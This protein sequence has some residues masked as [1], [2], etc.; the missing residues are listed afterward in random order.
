MYII[1]L[2]YIIDVGTFLLLTVLSSSITSSVGDNPLLV[3]DLTYGSSTQSL[4][5]AMPTL[6]WTTDLSNVDMSAQTS[7]RLGDT[8]FESRLTIMNINS[9]YCG[10]FSCTGSDINTAQ[11]S[12]ASTRVDVGML[13]CIVRQQYN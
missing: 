11:P 1:F 2:P 5:A 9:S 3:C 7:S 4:D 8:R 12:T 6:T 10:E 13:L